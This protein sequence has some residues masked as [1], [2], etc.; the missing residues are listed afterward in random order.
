MKTLWNKLLDWC[1]K[2]KY[3]IILDWGGTVG[4]KWYGGYQMKTN[5]NPEVWI[6][7]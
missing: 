1:V 4:W 5:V 2:F 7:T 3:P 6:D